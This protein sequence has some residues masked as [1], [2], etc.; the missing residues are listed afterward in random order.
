MR[1]PRPSATASV[2]S[3]VA[4]SAVLL[5]CRRWEEDSPIRP[6]PAPTRPCPPGVAEPS[7]A[8]EP[9]ITA[10][11][12]GTTS[13]LFDDGTTKILSDGFVTRPSMWR[14]ALH[15]IGPD[16]LRIVE[17]LDSL[18]IAWPGANGPGRTP[19]SAVFTMHSDYDH[20]MDA[21]MFARLAEADLV[22]SS[23][24]LNIG[25]GG[26]VPEARLRGVTAGVP[27]QYGKFELTFL[28]SRHGKPYLFGGKVTR[29]LDPP[30]PVW[31]WKSDS[32]YSVLIRHGQRT[33]LLLGSANFVPGALDGQCVDVV[34]LAIGSLG[35]RSEEFINGYWNEVVRATRARRVILVHWDNFFRSLDK[36]LRPMPRPGDY[37]AR[38]MR[39]LR[40]LAAEDGVD[41]MVPERWT[42]TDPF[43]KLPARRPPSP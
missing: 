32:I 41:L 23:S 38:S 30:A 12:L 39:H 24:T 19:L 8:A 22:G 35:T 5:T 18:D 3:V 7:R 10:R 14:V 40:R 1:R 20:A 25:R 37:F 43:A 21:P 2:L 17:T 36:P 42:P 11:F 27:I 26:H 33:I 16:S 31:A 9:P 34:Y 28:P 6:S 15:V 29:R 4:L 13:L